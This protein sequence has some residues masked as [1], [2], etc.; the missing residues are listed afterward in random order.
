MIDCAITEIDKE[1]RRIAISQANI[2]K[3]YQSFMD[4][5]RKS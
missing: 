2:G 1:K 4:K 5:W 3:L